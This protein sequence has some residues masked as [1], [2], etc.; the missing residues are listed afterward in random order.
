MLPFIAAFC[1]QLAKDIIPSGKTGVSSEGGVMVARVS[2]E[3]D[4][5]F[6]GTSETVKC[7]ADGFWPQMGS[8]AL[9]RWS[10]PVRH[11]SYIFPL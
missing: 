11:S 10:H 1:P 2:C 6:I 8:C 3:S 4:A 9:T 5:I 7:D